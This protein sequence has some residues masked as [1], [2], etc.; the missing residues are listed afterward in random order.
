MLFSSLF[1]TVLKYLTILERIIRPY[2]FL[3][4]YLRWL[5]LSWFESDD[6]REMPTVQSVSKY[7]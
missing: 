5:L 4:S 3:W 7:V 2:S 6:E 1:S